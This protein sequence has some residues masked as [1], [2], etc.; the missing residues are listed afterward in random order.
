MLDT[1]EENS[2]LKA[3][4]GYYADLMGSALFG[5]AGAGV[6]AGAVPGAVPPTENAS[7]KRYSNLFVTR[8]L[9]IL[10]VDAAAGLFF[11]WG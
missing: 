3:A 1:P 11:G 6:G 2:G 9:L 8:L 4:A 5:G 7:V 10:A